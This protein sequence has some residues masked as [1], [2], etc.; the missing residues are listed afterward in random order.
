MLILSSLA[1]RNLEKIHKN[2]SLSRLHKTIQAP[3]DAHNLMHP[4]KEIQIHVLI[5]IQSQFFQFTFPELVTPM[6]QSYFYAPVTPV[7]LAQCFWHVPRKY[8]NNCSL[9]HPPFFTSSS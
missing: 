7:L 4:W 6:L 3:C 2:Q 1:I 9:L 8:F 5:F